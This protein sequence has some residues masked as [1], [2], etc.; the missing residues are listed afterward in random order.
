MTDRADLDG[1]LGALADDRDD[2][3]SVLLR[4]VRWAII[5]HPIAAR[6]AF[7]ALVLEGRRF[8]AT[9]DGQAWRDR[10]S[11]SELMRRGRSVWELATCNMLDDDPTRVLPTQLIDAFCHAATI[12]DLE[13]QLARR[14]EAEDDA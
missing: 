14:L 3:L 12:E 2:E 11:E 6:S 5:K 4:E 10:L 7:R 1:L 8:A 9:E 13:P